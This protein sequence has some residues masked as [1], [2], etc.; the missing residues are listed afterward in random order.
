[1]GDSKDSNDGE[2]DQRNSRSSSRKVNRR[3][4]KFTTTTTTN[5][6][7][8]KDM[9][10]DYIDKHGLKL[11]RNDVINLD[12]GETEDKSL[13]KKL[14]FSGTYPSFFIFMY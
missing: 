13:W 1:M 4:I 8:K 9:K 10:L 5:D 6:T 2:H 7:I 14:K 11:R 3:V 12:T